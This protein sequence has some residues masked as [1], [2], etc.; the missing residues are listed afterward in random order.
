[1]KLKLV[2]W[3]FYPS[4]YFEPYCTRFTNQ[5]EL[6]VFGGKVQEIMKKVSPTKTDSQGMVSTQAI[7]L[8]GRPSVQKTNIVHNFV[9]IVF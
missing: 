7:P 6:E 2:K 5:I 3:F 8:Y 1:M 4:S 9:L